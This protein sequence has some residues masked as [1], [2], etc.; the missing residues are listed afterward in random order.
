MEKELATHSS[1]YS[2]LENP[3]K[4]GAR[5]ATVN[6]VTKDSNA[7]Y[8]LNSNKNNA[9]VNTMYILTRCKVIA[10]SNTL[11]FIWILFLFLLALCTCFTLHC[12]FFSFIY[13][14]IYF[15]C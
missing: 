2:C 13:L 12:L 14:F 7:T 5:L 10:L 6:G 9:K 3:V 11:S 15:Y 1:K 4:R 8:E